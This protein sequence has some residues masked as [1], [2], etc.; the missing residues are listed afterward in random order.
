M[1]KI[2]S[3]VKQIPYAQET[4]Y[5]NL[6][7]LSHL[8]RLKDKIPADKVGE[9]SFDRDSI[10]FKVPMAGQV[11][12]QVVSREEP[13]TIKL[14]TVKSPVPLTFW[15]QLL[16]KEENACKMKL[17]VKAE[18]SPFLKGMIQKPLE[19]GL[20]KMADALAVI[21]YEEE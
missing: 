19:E 14:E 11:T 1:I 13:K 20:E 8:E 10:T 15:I 17:T 9:V 3:S 16:P 4:V 18:V 5:K 2:E 12:M 7:D 6:S 21:P